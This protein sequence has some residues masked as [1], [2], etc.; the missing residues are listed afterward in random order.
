MV[1][2][3]SCIWQPTVCIQQRPLGKANTI[4]T[5]NASSYRRDLKNLIEP[6]LSIRMLEASFCT[7]RFRNCRYLFTLD[8]KEPHNAWFHNSCAF[9]KGDARHIDCRC[10]SYTHHHTNSPFQIRPS[11][12]LVCSSL[13]MT[14]TTMTW[15]YIV[16]TIALPRTGKKYKSATAL[17][18]VPIPPLLLQ[19][20]EDRQCF[21]HRR[22]TI[23]VRESEWSDSPFDAWLQVSSHN[24]CN[25]SLDAGHG[26]AT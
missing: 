15:I 17:S 9:D 26:R 8:A 4:V 21:L 13:I 24:R 2:P 16:Q 5:R 12:K 20:D 14:P 25:F 10:H 7:R 11:R 19:I 22:S 18:S 6:C 3:N 23:L 1:G